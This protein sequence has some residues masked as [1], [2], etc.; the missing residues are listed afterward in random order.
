MSLSLQSQ[1]IQQEFAQDRIR[2]ELEAKPE[3]V[4]QL[5][6]SYL[7]RKGK[8][9]ALMEE[10]RSV[11]KEN[12]PAAGKT[13]NLVRQII[14]EG[15][16]DLKSKATTWE[17]AAALNRPPLD[18]T[19]PVGKHHLGSL[20]PVT[21]IRQQ[22][23]RVFKQLGFT[24]YDG[25]E[26]DSDFYNFSALNIP[27]HHPARDMQDTFYIDGPEKL[28]LRTQTSNIQIHAMLN[29][30][31][32]L[33]IIAPGRVFRCD[34]DM[35]HTPMFHQIEGFVVDEGIT[36]A[37]L[38][39]TI[40]AFLKA[41]FG[42]TLSTRFRPSFFP[43]VEPGAEFDVQC[44]VCKGKGCRT[45]KDTG[46]IEIG[47]CGMIH[48][49]VFEAVGYDSSTYSG[50]AFGFGIDRIAMSRFALPD[51]RQLFEGDYKFLG[52]FPIRTP[53]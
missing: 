13:I 23:Y 28:L 43:F 5:R 29:E 6:I 4:E 44:G 51:L 33:R 30:K 12:R 53:T 18:V 52:N 46:W 36:F 25:P 38:K 7:G 20:H 9:T 31:P 14:E 24:V 16:S 2:V 3:S 49:N 8:L 41:I 21:I 45:C 35:T 27:D 47:G 40:D 34:S 15:L 50:F 17:L 19:L 42:S 26:I 48:P 1:Q 10:L 39:G 32:P 22:L 37:H 11:S